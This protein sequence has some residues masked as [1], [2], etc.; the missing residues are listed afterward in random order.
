MIIINIWKNNHSWLIMCHLQEKISII[1]QNWLENFSVKGEDR[2]GNGAL[3]WGL[4]SYGEQPAE[5]SSAP[6]VKEGCALKT[7]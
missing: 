3:S 1:F 5:L 7:L 2:R 6:K 4:K